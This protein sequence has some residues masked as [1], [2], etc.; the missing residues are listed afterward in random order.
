MSCVWGSPWSPP[1]QGTVQPL[2]LT[3][4]PVLLPSS[5]LFIGVS[6]KISLAKGFCYQKREPLACITFIPLA[7]T[8][9]QRGTHQ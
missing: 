7:F 4:Q 3:W 9:C 5:V 6:H 1:P 8:E 2:Q